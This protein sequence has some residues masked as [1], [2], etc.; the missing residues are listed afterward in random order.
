[1]KIKELLTYK[2]TLLELLKQ[3]NT[4]WFV[5]WHHAD[6]TALKK[7]QS[8]SLRALQD[9]ETSLDMFIW[10][11]HDYS[12]WLTV[13][14]P[15]I[16]ELQNVTGQQIKR[17]SDRVMT[18]YGDWHTEHYFRKAADAIR[19]KWTAYKDLDAGTEEAYRALVNAGSSCSPEHFDTHIGCIGLVTQR[20]AEAN[21]HAVVK[22]F[23]TAGEYGGM[24]WILYANALFG[25][26]CIASKRYAY[27]ISKYGHKLFNY[28]RHSEHPYAWY[29][30]A[31]LLYKQLA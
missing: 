21:S 15:A 30:V 17:F 12:R 10:I 2:P 26:E 29:V 4:N 20:A 13:G 1:M 19:T 3:K 28:G 9:C 22:A 18:E 6:S 23:T 31:Q 16:D 14:M 8:S 11:F 25:M 5:D 7:G 27:R 24:W